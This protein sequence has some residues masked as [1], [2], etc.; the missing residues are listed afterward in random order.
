MQFYKPARQHPV[1]FMLFRF[2]SWSFSPWYFFSLIS[3]YCWPLPLPHLHSHHPVQ[4]LNLNSFPHADLRQELAVQQKQEKPRTPMPSSVAA[5]R[6]DIAVQATSSVPS[7]PVAHRAPSSSFTTPGACRR[8]KENGVERT[9]F[10]SQSFHEWERNWAGLGSREQTGMLQGR[11]LR[12]VRRASCVWGSREQRSLGWAGKQSLI[13]R[14]LCS[15]HRKVRPSISRHFHSSPETRNLL[16]EY[17][18]FRM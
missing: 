8:G 7:T 17:E 11:A 14:G 10:A 15:C 18:L 9:F 12:P 16:V 5:E 4:R 13:W 6:T 1:G 2:S 3:A